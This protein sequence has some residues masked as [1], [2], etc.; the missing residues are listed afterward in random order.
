MMSLERIITLREFLLDKIEISLS[1]NEK[2]YNRW[3]EKERNICQCKTCGNPY[4]IIN[5][6]D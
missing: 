3:R 4:G 1:F 2:G 6:Q 5:P